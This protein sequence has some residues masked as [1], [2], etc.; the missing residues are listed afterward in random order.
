M[1]G[2]SLYYQVITLK[3]LVSHESLTVTDEIRNELLMTPEEIKELKRTNMLI[4]K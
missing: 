2:M 1:S 3:I 4:I